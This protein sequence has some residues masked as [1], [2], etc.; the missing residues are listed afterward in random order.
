MNLR[1][2]TFDGFQ[3]ADSI[4]TL[5]TKGFMTGTQSVDRKSAPYQI[6]KMALYDGRLEIPEY[7]KLLKELISLEKDA[8]T[9][10]VDHPVNGSK[11]IADAPRSL[12]AAWGA[13]RGDSAVDSGVPSRR[14]R[15]LSGIGLVF[16]RLTPLSPRRDLSDQPTS[17]HVPPGGGGLQ[18]VAGHRLAA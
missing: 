1:W 13:T 5:R 17:D 6:N 8:Q 16:S 18:T 3:S 12:G 10:K 14:R 9:G 2:F 11:D 7:P 4:Q 15:R